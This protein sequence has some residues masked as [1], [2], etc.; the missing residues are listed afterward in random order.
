MPKYGK[1]KSSAW[2]RVLVGKASR[3]QSPGSP[4]MQ[5]SGA[6]DVS[7]EEGSRDR[8]EVDTSIPTRPR[9]HLQ[10]SFQDGNGSLHPQRSVHY[11]LI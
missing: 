6:E 1:S 11:D 3:L 5:L 4:P 7:G 8:R 2:K 10:R 9:R